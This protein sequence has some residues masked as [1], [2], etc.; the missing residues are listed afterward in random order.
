[1]KQVQRIGVSL[2]TE[3]LSE[4][5]ELVAEQGYH[6]RSEAIRDLIRNRLT[7]EQLAHPDTRAV[8][9]VFV[10]YDHHRPQLAQK[11][12][13][14]QHSHLLKTISSMHLHLDHHNCLEVILLRG[15]VGDITKLGDNI[16]SLKGVKLGRVNLI[17]AAE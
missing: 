16:V 13:R 6:N 11:L 8:A 7:A 4:F 9:A 2:E 3:L 10:V 1:M 14:L 15:K 17:T 5:D 12:I